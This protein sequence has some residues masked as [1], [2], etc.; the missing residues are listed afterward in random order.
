MDRNRVFGMKVS[1]PAETK[2]Q[3]ATR[4]SWFFDVLMKTLQRRHRKIFRGHLL[5]LAHHLSLVSAVAVQRNQQGRRQLRRQIEIVVEL[6]LARQRLFACDSVVVIRHIYTVD[7]PSDCP[8]A[9]ITS[10]F[11]RCRSC[12][13]LCY[14]SVLC[15]S[16]VSAFDKWIHHRPTEDT[17]FAQS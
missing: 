4:L 6:D 15:V 3:R 14:L 10:F 17:K 11:H 9:Y 5:R 2:T 7:S 13:S 16:V 12:L 8:S 1:E